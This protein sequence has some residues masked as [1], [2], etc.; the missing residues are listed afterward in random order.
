MSKLLGRSPVLRWDGPGLTVGGGR[1][2]GLTLH[3]HLRPEGR[4]TVGSTSVAVRTTPG[5]YLFAVVGEV[6]CRV[7]VPVE[8]EAARGTGVGAFREG[9]LG[10][11]RAAPG[12]G[13]AGGV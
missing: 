11:H 12:T 2:A 8:D 9:E 6:A 13:L 1:P 5:Q 3:G 7:L 10:F 4:L